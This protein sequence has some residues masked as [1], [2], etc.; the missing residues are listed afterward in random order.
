MISYEPFWNMLKNRGESWYSLEHKYKISTAE[1]SRLKNNMNITTETVNFLCETFD[2]TIP[3]I[4]V[5]IK[6]NTENDSSKES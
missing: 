5:F 6:S 3:D 4:M 2:C 1:L